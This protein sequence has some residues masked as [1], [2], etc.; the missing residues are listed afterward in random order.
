MVILI[1]ALPQ[2]L[3]VHCGSPKADAQLRFGVHRLAEEL[4][5]CSLL[6]V[7]L[8]YLSEA[9]EMEDQDVGQCP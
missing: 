4:E 2:G 8:Q 1:G 9:L 7:N 6:R 3:R 5:C